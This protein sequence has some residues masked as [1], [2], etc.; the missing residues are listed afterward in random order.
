MKQLHITLK[1]NNNQSF[2]NNKAVYMAQC[3]SDIFKLNQY[4]MCV[5]NDVMDMLV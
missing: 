2:H 5:L 4:L 3:T 1:H